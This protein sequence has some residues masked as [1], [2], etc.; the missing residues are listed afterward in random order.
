MYDS[1]YLFWRG[2]SKVPWTRYT[3]GFFSANDEWKV[4]FFFFVKPTY[5]FFFLQHTTWSHTLCTD[6]KE[7]EK[8][9]R[10]IIV[11]DELAVNTTRVQKLSFV[12]AT[13]EV[14]GKVLF[15]V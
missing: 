14:F 13:S 1:T 5:F 6:A 10:F 12:F 7:T 3:S 9:S 15:H 8:L 4:I 11:K 2:P